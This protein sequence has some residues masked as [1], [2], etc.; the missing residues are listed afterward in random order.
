MIYRS[1]K[2]AVKSV[3]TLFLVSLAA[4]PFVMKSKAF[5]QEEV[6]TDTFTF[7]SSSD[8]QANITDYIKDFVTVPEGGLDWKLFA[9]TESDPFT[10]EDE[11]GIYVVGVRPVFKEA[12]KKYDGK[13]ILLQGYMFPLDA[14]DKQTKFLYGPFPMSCPFHYHIGA[15]LVIEVHPKEPVL[16]EW[17]AVNI[18][19]RLELVPQDDEFNVFYRLHDATLEQQ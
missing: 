8:M 9:E 18:K 19:G 3:F 4:V 13:V 17:D 14:E 1:F 12:L 2:I 11:A 7:S 5:T 6:V 15:N 10:E 16:F